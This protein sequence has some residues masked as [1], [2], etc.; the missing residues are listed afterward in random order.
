M[1]TQLSKPAHGKAS[2]TE[3]YKQQ[4]VELWRNSGRSA[5]RLQLS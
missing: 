1:K 2:Y 4:A 3:E 5:A